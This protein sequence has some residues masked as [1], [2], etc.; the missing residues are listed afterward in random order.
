MWHLWGMCRPYTLP[1]CC[2][3]KELGEVAAKEAAAELASPTLGESTASGES[4][5]ILAWRTTVEHGGTIEL[6]FVPMQASKKSI[7]Y[8]FGYDFWRAWQLRLL[9]HVLKLRTESGDLC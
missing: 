1:S 7:V 8:R 9:E 6:E 3:Y 5:W 4:G 2:R